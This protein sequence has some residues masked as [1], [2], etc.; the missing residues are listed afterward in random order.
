M[1]ATHQFVLPSGPRF[2]LGRK[3]AVAVG[4]SLLVSALSFFLALFLAIVTLF[5][6]GLARNARPDTTIAYRVVAAPVAIAAVPIAIAASLWWQLARDR[7][8]RRSYSEWQ[9]DERT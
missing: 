7:R 5:V 8:L 2:H 9:G 1:N 6:V 4:V 3:A